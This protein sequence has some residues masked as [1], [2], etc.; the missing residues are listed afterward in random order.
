MASYSLESKRVWIAGHR[1]M[2]GSA[3]VRALH[4]R[5]LT[6]LKVERGELDLRRQAEVEDWMKRQRPQ[7]VFL[8]AAR[9]G[10][11]L[12]NST[13]P[14]EFLYDN[15]A[16]QTNI[17]HAAHNC[18]VEKLLLLG[19]TCIYPRMS[20]QPIREEALLSGPLESTN[21]WYALAKI[22]GLKLAAAYR[23]Q[24]GR[25]F[26]SA[27]PTNLYGPNDNFGSASSHVLPA[28]IRRIHNAKAEGRFSEY[29]PEGGVGP[30]R[31]M[32]L[33]RCFW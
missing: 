30:L 16:I 11:I 13:R 24:Y 7:A 23:L 32:R 10:G 1:G 5:R 17:I 18:G 19:S 21:Q 25:D 2:V 27:M 20:E 4:G 31:R 29:G 8:A 6:L 12:A 15:L 33:T 26:I 9:V 3:L 22:T 14:A 28:L